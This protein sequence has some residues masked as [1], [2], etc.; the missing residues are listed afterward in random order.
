VDDVGEAAADHEVGLAEVAV[1]DDDRLGTKRDPQRG[2]VLRKPEHHPPPH[3]GG[4]CGISRHASLNDPEDRRRD[5]V[6]DHA[7]EPDP[8]TVVPLWHRQIL[9]IGAIGEVVSAR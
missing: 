2:E 7:A 4:E 1:L 9:G 5:A 8:L 3:R 6:L